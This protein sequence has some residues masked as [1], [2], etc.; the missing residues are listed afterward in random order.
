M[1]IPKERPEPVTVPLL[2]I[3]RLS[4]GCYIQHIGPFKQLKIVIYVCLYVLRISFKTNYVTFTHN[5]KRL[6]VSQH[7]TDTP[8]LRF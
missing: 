3:C 2:S 8:E 5:N 1:V 6:S 4:L 7:S